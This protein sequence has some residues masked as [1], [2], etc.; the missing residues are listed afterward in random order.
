MGHAISK[1]GPHDFEIIPKFG[2][3]A[4]KDNEL[5]KSR[6]WQSRILIHFLCTLCQKTVNL[7]PEKVGGRVSKDENAPSIPINFLGFRFPISAVGF[8]PS[9]FVWGKKRILSWRV[10]DGKFCISVGQNFCQISGKI[11]GNFGKNAKK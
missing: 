7:A 3:A 1:F 2:R 10:T 8:P 11:M 6:P 9:D 4:Q 5:R